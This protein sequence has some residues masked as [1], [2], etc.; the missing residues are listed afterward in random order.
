MSEACQG[1][2]LRGD[3][4]VPKGPGSPLRSVRDDN[5]SVAVQPLAEGRRIEGSWLK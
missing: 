1:L 4:R 5:L 3:G 2:A